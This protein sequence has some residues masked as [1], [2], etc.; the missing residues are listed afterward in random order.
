MEI[1]IDYIS[2]IDYSHRSSFPFFN[3]SPRNNGQSKINFRIRGKGL[4]DYHS[5]LDNN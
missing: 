1:R 2:D 3:G 4:C 5:Q